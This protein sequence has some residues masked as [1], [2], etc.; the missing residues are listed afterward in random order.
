MASV[1]ASPAQDTAD[2]G[3]TRLQET[4]HQYVSYTMPFSSLYAHSLATVSFV[5]KSACGLLVHS[6]HDLYISP[7]YSIT[8]WIRQGVR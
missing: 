1:M 8:V 2:L 3:V 4:C 6:G 7:L 5:E